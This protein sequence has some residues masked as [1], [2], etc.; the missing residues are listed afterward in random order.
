MLRGSLG[1]TGIVLAILWLL[2]TST[3][4]QTTFGSITGTVTDP[5]GALI[6]G[7]SVTVTNDDTGAKRSA[8]TSSGGVFNVTDLNVGSY[9]LR[10]ASPGFATY[11]Q[12]GLALSANRVVNVDVQL[13]IAAA[14]TTTEVKGGDSRHR[15]GEQRPLEREDQP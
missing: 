11:E 1:A 14:T 6:V 15:D 7:A 3:S 12:R 13:S 2:S 8:P 10:V 9:T 4:A 5:A